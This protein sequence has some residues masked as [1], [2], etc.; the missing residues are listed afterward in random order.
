MRFYAAVFAAAALVGGIAG[1]R[2][3]AAAQETK[4]AEKT[5]TGA[6]FS[7]EN[8]AKMREF[9][10]V[11][12]IV[13]KN[14]V[15]EVSDEKLMENAIR[16]M[17]EGLDPHS[18]YFAAEDLGAFRKSMRAEEYGGVGIYIG[19]KNGWIEIISPIDNTPAARAG[20]RAGDIIVKID[21]DGARGLGID[22]AVERMRGKEGAIIVLEVVTPGGEDRRPRK[23]E[24]RREKITAPTAVGGV[25]EPDYAYLRINRFQHETVGDLVKVLNKVYEKNGRPL[26]GIVLDLRNNPGGLLDSSA[27]VA[28]VFLPKGVTV[29]SDRGRGEENYL[30]AE[31]SKYRGLR[32]P[33]EVKKV[34]LAVLVNNGSA[35]ASE[36][37]AGALQDHR[38]AVI[39]GRRTYGKASVQSLLRLPS[40]DKKT[41]VKL[42]T[43]RYFTPLG[44]SIQAVGIEPDIEVAAQKSVEPAED[45]FTL[46]EK[47]LPRH[48]E[49][50]ESDAENSES[51]ED[52]PDEKPFIPKDD[53][54]YDQALVALKALA[55]AGN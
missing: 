12:R 9:A 18:A 34:R 46:S 35:S 8:L 49:N 30:V 43:A 36:I 7:P 40:T 37:V 1:A 32:N 27:G 24:L 31:A 47:D 29:V 21:G 23:V 15:E 25:A 52:A 6:A 16:G 13:K 19:E 45:D 55:V 4:N 3:N 51:S 54:Q 53:H 48:L 22:K 33:E 44:R 28:A 50:E 20:L 17:I 14:Y 2:Y 39:V 5:Q 41:G 38:R 42:T 26:R 11:F 10:E